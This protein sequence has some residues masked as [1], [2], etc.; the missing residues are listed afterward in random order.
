MEASAWLGVGRLF[1]SLPSACLIHIDEIRSGID[2]VRMI[3]F[4]AEGPAWGISVASRPSGWWFRTLLGL[5]SSEPDEPFD[6]G[7]LFLARSSTPH[8]EKISTS[9]RFIYSNSI[10]AGTGRASS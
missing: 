10:N 8:G 5:D 4:F 2:P 1:H 3:E 7:L 9:S 6:I